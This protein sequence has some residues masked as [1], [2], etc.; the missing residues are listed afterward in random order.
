MQ[1]AEALAPDESLAIDNTGQLD[2]GSEPE[3]SAVVRMQLMLFNRYMVPTFT[4]VVASTLFLAYILYPGV[5]HFVLLVWVS[6]MFALLVLRAALV[7]LFNRVRDREFN[8]EWWRFILTTSTLALGLCWGSAGIYLFPELPLH[9]AFLLMILVGVAAGSVPVLATLSTAG[10][11]FLVTVLS[12]LIISLVIQGDE[13]YQAMAAVVAIYLLFLMVTFT[14]I[15]RGTL[16]AI[17]LHFNNLELL[18]SLQSSQSQKGNL[19]EKLRSEVDEKNRAMLDMQLAMRTAEQASKEKDQFLATM[20][21]EIRTPMNGVIGALDLLDSMTLSQEQQELI[22]TASRSAESLMSIIN[23]ILD[24]SKI[25]SGQLELERIPLN[26][27]QNTADVAALWRQKALYQ[28]LD[29]KLE[30]TDDV[31]YDVVGDPTRYRQILNNLLS[32]AIKFTEKGRVGL[33]LSLARESRMAY[34]LRVEV[35]DTG[36]GIQPAAREK[37]FKP[38]TQ[39]D[40]SMARRFGGTGLGL[41]ITQRLVDMMGGQIDIETEPGKGSIFWLTVKMWRPESAE[42]KHRQ[43]LR[44]LRVLFVGDR[45][46]YKRSL[47]M[48]LKKFGI[49]SEIAEGAKAALEKLDYALKVG[50]TWSY[51]VLL[52][53]E[54]MQ[55]GDVLQFAEEIYKSRLL[56]GVGIVLVGSEGSY[57]LRKGAAMRCIDQLLMVPFTPDTLEETLGNF[58]SHGKYSHVSTGSP[59]RKDDRGARDAVKQQ[60]NQASEAMQGGSTGAFAPLAGR[61]LVVE[62]NEINRQITTSMLKQMGL[63]VAE[64]ENGIEA[65][66]LFQKEEPYDLILMDVQMPRLG[67]CEATGLMRKIET[68]D[69]RPRVPIIAM[70]ANAMKGDRE[71]CLDAGMDSYLAKPVKRDALYNELS[72]WLAPGSRVEGEIREATDKPRQKA[73]PVRVLIV[74]DDEYGQILVTKMLEKMGIKTLSARNGF[75]AVK[76][77]TSKTPDLVLMDCQMPG[78]DGFEAT[79]KI[80]EHEKRHGY[81]PVPIVAMTANTLPQDQQKCFSVGMD[82]FLGKPVTIKALMAKIDDWLKQSTSVHSEQRG[83]GGAAPVEQSTHLDTRTVEELREL[84]QEK[85]VP[86]IQTY[87]RDTPI[88]FKTMRE[89]IT[90]S[91]AEQLYRAAHSLKSASA[92]L[93]ANGLSELARQLEFMGREEDLKD[94]RD[95]FNEAVREYGIVRHALKKYLPA[96]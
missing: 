82:D 76:V 51:D 92:S 58:G 66:D 75:E 73:G 71:L 44:N 36:I 1:I 18:E 80:R 68:S 86:I 54:Y 64:A 42:W 17:K 30:I 40:G 53:D 20:S 61:I 3:G 63:E 65:V 31:P 4:F 46:T 5:D 37:L 59:K 95:L 96:S 74:E 49:T 21:H 62:D 77:A 57:T 33:R 34:T 84:M 87:M 25:E 28:G 9:Q 6:V 88:R 55:Q 45:E 94:A 48:P 79:S 70:T 38:F 47:A 50:K 32:N 93:G 7:P 16:K 69:S 52:I 10:L 23:D 2:A 43:E 90:A 35:S 22:V 81:S 89:A 60:L 39:A 85:F 41:S 26:I 13:A 8:T 19:V 91:D 11:L 78:M 67:G 27:R 83:K 29:F 24:L 14:Q 56:T 72:K 15:H 12:P